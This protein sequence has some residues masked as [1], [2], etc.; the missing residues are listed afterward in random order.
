MFN[1]HL[2]ELSANHLNI[3]L[4]LDKSRNRHFY[5]M[6]NCN[7]GNWGTFCLQACFWCI[8]SN[9]CVDLSL[10]CQSVPHKHQLGLASVWCR[11][12]AITQSFRGKI[13]VTPSNTPEKHNRWFSNMHPGLGCP[14]LIFHAGKVELLVLWAFMCC[15]V[16]LLSAVLQFALR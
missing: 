4:F 7:M 12:W 5:F 3:G 15:N 11:L 1:A 13:S 16:C 14:F 8:L 2:N 9:L 6:R 10:D